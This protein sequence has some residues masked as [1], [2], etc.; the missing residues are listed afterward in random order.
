MNKEGDILIG[1]RQCPHVEGVI[2][3]VCELPASK[4]EGRANRDRP[5]LLGSCIQ[6]LG[7]N[8]GCCS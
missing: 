6:L 1:T 3:G 2:A 8:V 7:A 5:W 4:I